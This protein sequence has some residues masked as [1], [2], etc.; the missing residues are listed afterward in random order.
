MFLTPSVAISV[1]MPHAS[2]KTKPTKIGLNDK[3]DVLTHIS[4][5][6]RGKTT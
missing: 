2:G 3:R 1:R 6:D 4:G 5:R